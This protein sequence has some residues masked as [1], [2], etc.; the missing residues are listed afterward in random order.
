MR[1]QAKDAVQK[2]KDLFLQSPAKLQAA[3]V[4]GG[5]RRK[6]L[7]APRRLSSSN[8]H[9]AGKRVV[10]SGG[11]A[12]IKNAG[13][14]LSNDKLDRLEKENKEDGASSVVE[15]RGEEEGRKKEVEE[16][17]ERGEGRKKGAGEKG[18]RGDGTKEGVEKANRDTKEPET[19]MSSAC[20][21]AAVQSGAVQSVAG[22]GESRASVVPE[23]SPLRR[24][25][26]RSHR[27]DYSG[28]L[29]SESSEG[30]ADQ[31]VPS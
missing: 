30:E 13:Q 12:R 9:L 8:P 24:S 22:E 18:E 2:L 1:R 17:G 6:P 5:A 4:V 31:T 29:G 19:S 11:G 27:I 7:I 14:Q 3:K 26:R 25:G 28:M 23:Q 21:T 15:E 10:S 20:E 16:K